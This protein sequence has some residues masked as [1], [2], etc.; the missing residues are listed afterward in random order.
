MGFCPITPVLEA[1]VNGRCMSTLE[2]RLAMATLNGD[3]QSKGRPGAA[4]K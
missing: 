1:R 2:S 3:K 4:C